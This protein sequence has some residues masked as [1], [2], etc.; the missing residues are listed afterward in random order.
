MLEQSVKKFDFVSDFSFGMKFLPLGQGTW[1]EILP[2]YLPQHRA[3][4]SSM[5][6]GW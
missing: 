5:A 4:C 2:E 3:V 1:Q 6:T